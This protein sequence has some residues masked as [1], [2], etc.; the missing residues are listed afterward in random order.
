MIDETAIVPTESDPL[1]LLEVTAN[2]T[3]SLN[4]LL[5]HFAK[6]CVDVARERR[7]EIEARLTARL[8]ELAAIFLSLDR[9]H[10]SEV[11][12]RQ[13]QFQA[14]SVLLDLAKGSGDP[15]LMT[16]AMQCFKQYVQSAPT[17]T[18]DFSEAMT[19]VNS[20]VDLFPAAEPDK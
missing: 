10:A 6:M 19:K 3:K 14:L 16:E 18:R 20:A 12:D 2:A 1:R 9:R 4:P 7:L 11:A 5:G 13:L 17:F 15:R 8:Q